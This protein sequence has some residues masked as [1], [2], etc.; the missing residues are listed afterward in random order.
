MAQKKIINIDTQNAQKNVSELNQDLQETK[1]LVNQINGTDVKK[2]GSNID[3]VQSKVEA[4]NNTL[5]STKQIDLG[6]VTAN[7]AKVGAGISGAFNLVNTAINLMGGESEETTKAV[8]ALQSAML[9][10]VQFAAV[11]EGISALGSLRDSLLEVLQL[12][13]GTEITDYITKAVAFNVKDLFVPS[14]DE[15]GKVITEY[16]GAVYTEKLEEWVKQF[17][18]SIDDIFT[19]EL[20]QK[21][22]KLG[23]EWINTYGS[24]YTKS[25]EGLDYFQVEAKLYEK[26]INDFAKANQDA[27]TSYQKWSLIVKKGIPFA[28]LAT[29]VVELVKGIRKAIKQTEDEY[30]AH[31]DK[32]NKETEQALKEQRELMEFN[33]ALAEKIAKKQ[34]GGDDIKV[35]EKV[36]AGYEKQLN[37]INKRIGELAG[38]PLYSK[39]AD[40]LVDL[41]AKLSVSDAKSEEYYQILLRIVEVQDL[42]KDSKVLALDKGTQAQIDELNKDAEFWTEKLKE[43]RRLLLEQQI[44]A[45]ATVKEVEK[46]LVEANWQLDKLLLTTKELNEI[47][48]ELSNPAN[49]RDKRI[50][51]L[52]KVLTGA[53]QQIEILNDVMMRF[54]ESSLG[55][56]GQYQNVVSDFSNM[57]QQMTRI[58][59]ENGEVGWGS[60][61]DMAASGIASVGTLLNAL[62]D[63]QDTSNKEGF[64]AQKKYQISASVMNMLAGILSAWTSAMQLPF[65]A[66][67]ILGAANSAMIASLG[68]VQIA[69]IKSQQF[70]GSANVSGNAIN[71]TIIPPV[72][73]SSL[74]QGAQTEGAIRDTRQYVSVVEIDK[75]QK[76][77]NVT[78]NESRY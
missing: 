41:E 42:M 4:L 65:P 32:I 25:S 1:N 62:G 49:G 19:E 8:Q 30:K 73:Y 71:S 12:V 58:I 54:G 24:Y 13:S 18:K 77:V 20:G 57:F 66:N 28:I 27:I 3:A 15:F 74:V 75:V 26:A 2:V 72:Q 29:G 7:V 5:Q 46:P 16:G 56:S 31:L 69:K 11:A 68:A 43:A 63:E 37:S 60:W 51:Y 50:E 78:E 67:T 55:L 14:I 76:R 36:I 40:E 22:Q 35:Y 39:W 34:Y 59:L 38:Q 48:D 33:A 6:T 45:G 23:D 61:V 53:Q 9:L 52:V 44:I 70:G 17:G 64:E 47:V 10:P 21:I